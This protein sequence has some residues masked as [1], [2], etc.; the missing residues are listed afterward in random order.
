MRRPILATVSV[1]SLLLPAGMESQAPHEQSALELL[2]A[3]KKG[4]DELLEKQQKTLEGL[5][6]IEEQARQL[7]IF[8][9]RA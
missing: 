2:Q 5:D 3:L 6:K 1:L 7:K 4:N 9:K 8:V